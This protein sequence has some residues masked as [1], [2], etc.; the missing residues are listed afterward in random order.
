MA[1]DQTDQD[2]GESAPRVEV[3]MVQRVNLKIELV[4]LEVNFSSHR[5]KVTKQSSLIHLLIV[6]TP[7]DLSFSKQKEHKP[8]PNLNFKLP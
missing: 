1:V 6:K 7:Q 2:R 8:L 5:I 4:L 3:G